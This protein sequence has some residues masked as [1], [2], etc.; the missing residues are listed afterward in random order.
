MEAPVRNRRNAHRRL[1][2]AR[3][4]P[5]CRQVRPQEVEAFR[6]LL[7]RPFSL[8]LASFC[9]LLSSSTRR[10]TRSPVADR[11]PRRGQITRAFG[12][13]ARQAGAGLPAAGFS[14]RPQGPAGCARRRN[15]K[16]TGSDGVLGAPRAN[17]RRLVD[18]GTGPRAPIFMPLPTSRPLLATGVAQTLERSAVYESLGVRMEYDDRSNQV[19][20]NADLL[21]VSPGVSEGRNLPAPPPVEITIRR[22]ILAA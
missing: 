9:K 14:E 18:C 1:P 3:R 11:S 8:F 7:G 12:L 22:P 5:R 10:S 2:R 21:R 16:T 17:E 13:D 4:R 20:V 19:L 6:A 15:G